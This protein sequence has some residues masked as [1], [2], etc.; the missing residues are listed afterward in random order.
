[1][2]QHPC[3]SDDNISRLGDRKDEVIQSV[4]KEFSESDRILSRWKQRILR[5]YELYQMVQKRKH[6]QGL[7][8]IFVPELLRAVETIVGK[9]Y[10]VLF[11]QP[12]WFEYVERAEDFEQGGALALTG[13]TKYQMEENSFKSRTMDSIRQMVI[14]GLTVRKMCWDFDEVERTIPGKPDSNGKPTKQKKIETIK[15]TWTFEPVDLL[16]FQISD[17]NIPYNDLQKSRWIGEQ[18]I[19]TKVWVDD[20]TRRGWFSKAMKAELE[21]QPKPASSTATNNV[22]NKLQSSGFNQVGTSDKYEI[23]ER[24]GLVKAEWVYTSDELTIE[25]LD[26]DDLVEGVIVIANKCA[27]LKLEKN[28]HWHNQKPYVACPYVPKEGELPG[29]GACQIGESLQEEINDTR[30][31]T[32]DNKTMILA[33]MWLRS[34]TSGIKNDSLRMRPN[35]IIDTFDVEGLVPLRPPMVTQVGTSMEGVAKNDLREGAGA[36]SNLQ[37]I[38]QAGV[39]TATESTQINQDSMGRLLLTAK[40]YAELILKP[41]LVFAEYLNY[42]YYDHIK[43]INVLGKVGVKFKKLTIAEIAG[44]HKDVIIHIDVDGTENPAVRRQQYMSF[45]GQTL[46]LPPQLIAFH[47]KAL[48]KGYGMFFSGH[49]LD[50]IYPN[51]SPDPEAQLTPEEEKDMIVASKVVLATRGQDHEKYIK[52]HEKEFDEMKYGLD[53]EQFGM[54]HKLIISHYTLLKAE[55]EAQHQQMMQQ[56]QEQEAQGN[57]STGKTP[58]SSPSTMTPAPSVG[59]LGR[60]TAQ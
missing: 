38:A 60:A 24:W 8:N 9:I 41:T 4:L 33:T 27:I 59:S 15:D 40:L 2:K 50:E 6:Y 37:G 35:G 11:A 46:Q 28:P 10:G 44:G 22:N 36:A 12:D 13:L 26:G 5:Y 17:I 56:M 48:D 47:W 14:A 55:V 53:E 20:K 7:A 34:K 49:S 45:V 23:I 25:G 1:M 43:A 54:Y 51:P 19:A 32:M 16:T 29:I 31:Q 57:S 42:Q 3:L 21:D 18:Y 52:Y 58:N 39:G 30:N